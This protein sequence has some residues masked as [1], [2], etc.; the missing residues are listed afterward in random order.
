MVSER[1]GLLDSGSD[2]LVIWDTSEDGLEAESWT[3]NSLVRI[4]EDAAEEGVSPESI[5][6]ELS[7]QEECARHSFVDWRPLCVGY[8]NGPDGAMGYVS[9]GKWQSD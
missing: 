1:T 2:A 3:G 4:T 9:L 7:S 8:R 6:A 5:L